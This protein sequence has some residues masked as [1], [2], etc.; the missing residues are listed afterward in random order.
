MTERFNSAMGGYTCDGPRCQRLLWAGVRAKTEPSKRHFIY[1]VKPEE[2]VELDNRI[3]CSKTCAD[4]HTRSSE[5]G[6]DSP[7]GR[8][9]DR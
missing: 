9:S 3:F 4:N 8:H 1:S 6:T 2:V 5:N 7:R